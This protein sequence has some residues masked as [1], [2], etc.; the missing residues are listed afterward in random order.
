[1]SPAVIP[2]TKSHDA[3]PFGERA[4]LSINE[5]CQM[6]GIAR[7]TVYKAIAA[8]DLFPCRY[9]RRVFITQSEMKRFVESMIGNRRA[10][11]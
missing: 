7:S 11:P 3:I 8:G 6:V 9:G 2:K 10:R 1:M 4:A 5:F